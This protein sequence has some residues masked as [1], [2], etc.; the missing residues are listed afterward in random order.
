[1]KNTYTYTARSANNP[2]DVVLFTLSD[3]SLYVGVAAPL[4]LAEQAVEGAEGEEGLGE[5]IPDVAK[6][7]AV[8]TWQRITHPFHIG[9]VEARSTRGGLQVRCWTRTA[10]LRLAPVIFA[11]RKVDNPVA[12]EAFVDEIDRRKE[13]AVGPRRLPGLLDYWAGWLAGAF[14]L[15][16]G[17]AIWLLKRAREVEP[18]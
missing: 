1:M 14:A 13:A 4:E 15:F 16:T 17:A 11:F 6:P 10:G 2:E 18:S 5:Q 8:S 3:H 12:A 7:A 9:D